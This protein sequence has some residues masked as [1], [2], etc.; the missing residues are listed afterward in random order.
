MSQS[1]W[2]EN[3]F[4]NHDKRVHICTRM[5]S[6][7]VFSLCLA[8]EG[9][10]ACHCSGSNPRYSNKAEACKYESSVPGAK[11]FTG[12]ERTVTSGWRG[13]YILQDQTH[14]SLEESWEKTSTCC[15]D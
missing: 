2:N 13:P 4:G 10:R 9:V 3:R 1:A 6:S 14:Q 7:V 11:I 8:D 5:L 12:I 15:T